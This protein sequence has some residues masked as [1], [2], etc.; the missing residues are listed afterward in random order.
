MIES[1]VV[2]DDFGGRRGIGPGVRLRGEAVIVRGLMHDGD[3][4]AAR[5]EITFRGDLAGPVARLRS[6]DGLLQ[7]PAVAVYTTLQMSRPGSS[8]A[9]VVA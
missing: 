6:A 2:D 4:V 9:S 3:E 8:A 7:R 1:R 5:I